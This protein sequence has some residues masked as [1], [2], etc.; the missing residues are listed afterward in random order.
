MLKVKLLSYTPN[1][2]EV[3]AS[4]AKLCY[5]PVGIE[6]ITE[7]LDSESIDKFIGSLA[8][9]KHL[10]PFEHASFSFAVEGVSRTLTHQLVRH[11][12]ASFSQQSQ[13]YVKE[14]TFEY[15]IPPSIQENEKAKELFINHMS[16]S[17]KAYDELVEELVIT[18]IIDSDKYED[19]YK[20]ITELQ[21]EDSDWNVNAIYK[22]MSSENEGREDYIQLFKDKNGKLYSKLEKEAIEDARYVFP[23][24]TETKI[25]ITM[26]ARSLMNFFTLRC[27]NRAQWEIRALADEMLSLVYE[28]A[29]AI[30]G[31]SGAPCIFGKCDQGAMSCGTVRTFEDIVNK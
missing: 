31:K 8:R 18:K 17:Q 12:I 11:R 23:N 10:S 15:I 30:F 22:T 25:A 19:W 4:A 28:V 21:G 27:C 24:A 3:V 7:N 1:P 13:R 14:N 9:I 29:P 20:D 2:E 6:E 26:N 16:E 5:S